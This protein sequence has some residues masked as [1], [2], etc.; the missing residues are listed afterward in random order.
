MTGGAAPT[1]ILIEDLHKSF[2][3]HRV[4]AG[5]SL[6]IVRGDM[7]AIV[8]GSGCGKTVLVNHVLGQHVPDR[9]RVLVARHDLP[10]AP[11]ADLADLSAAELD[12]LHV[13][14]GVVFQANA[15]FSG[16][17]FD[18][19]ALWQREVR[20]AEDA[21]ILPLARRA[22]EAVGLETDDEFLALD[23]EELSGGMSKRLAVARALVME[24]EVLFYDEPT[25]GLDPNS[26]SQIHDLIHVTHQ[27]GAR[28]RTTLIVTHDKDPAAQARAPG[29]H[30]PRGPA[31]VR[32]HLRR[33]RGLRRPGRAALLRRHARAPAPG[34]PRMTRCT[35]TVA[36]WPADD[37]AVR[38]VRGAVFTDEQ[39]I[40]AALDFDGSDAGCLEA[41]ARVEGRAVGTGRITADGHVGRMAVL[42]PWR[43]HGVGAALLEALVEAARAAGIVEVDLNAQCTAAGFYERLGFRT[44]GEPFDEVGIPHVRMVRRLAP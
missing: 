14:W 30:A 40:D 25:T 42:S 28:P 9:G 38:A 3:D 36:P 19:L 35:V 12:A 18:N 41:V 21:E 43:G 17:V 44:A 7:V 22:L 1:E 34:A 4:L 5:V 31:P 32:R 37:A 39:G 11:L 29:D 8:G 15:L 27:G 6:E 2:G 23:H 16:S 20:G 24:P 26:A 33:L 10:G 13:H